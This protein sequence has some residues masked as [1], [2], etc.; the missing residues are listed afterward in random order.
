MAH[1][2]KDYGNVYPKEVTHRL[3]DMAELAIRLGAISSIDRLGDVIFYD[4][5]EDGIGKWV[6]ETGGTGASVSLETAKSNSGGFSCKLVTGNLVDNY[7]NIRKLFYKF[8]LSKIGIE[9]RFILDTYDSIVQTWLYWYDGS[10]VKEAIIAYI[11]DLTLLRIW[12]SG[13]TWKTLATAVRL[14]QDTTTWH[15]MKI[16]IDL[17]SEK[18]ER[19]II[20][21]VQY[22]KTEE[23]IESRP[24][25]SLPHTNCGIEIDARV[26]A[27]VTNYIDDIIITQNEP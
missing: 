13:G 18:Y 19:I 16:V 1:G 12:V 6:S 21:G 3:D 5:F 17:N 4:D 10:T 15:S 7:A 14:Y 23:Y 20:N 24:D 25:T 2:T 8:Q 27:N 22:V 11:T 9:F 26:A